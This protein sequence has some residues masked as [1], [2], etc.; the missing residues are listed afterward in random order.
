M[1]QSRYGFHIIHVDDKQA[2]HVKTLDEV[3]DQI[4]P[5]IKQQKAAQAADQPGERSADAGPQRW[6]WKRPPP[7]KVFR[8]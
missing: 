2:A 7:P 3:K 6:A 8:S 1:V 5:I 4:E